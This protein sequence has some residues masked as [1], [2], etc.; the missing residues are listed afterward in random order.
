MNKFGAGVSSGTRNRF[1]KLCAKSKR[2]LM[3]GGI[4]DVD[5]FRDS[6]FVAARMEE[7][8]AMHNLLNKAENA[9]VAMA[10][11]DLT[12]RED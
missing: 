10:C 11:R 3:G 1:Q 5:D 2:K 12:M 4:A 7:T 8:S 9:A 6:L